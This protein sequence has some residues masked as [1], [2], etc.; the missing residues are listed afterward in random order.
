MYAREVRLGLVLYGGV[1]LAV[2]ENGVAR[3]LYHAVRGDGIYGLLKE[4]TDSDIVVDI[5]SGTSAGGVNGVM[6]SY[7]L[8]N[9]KDFTLVGDLWRDQADIDQLLRKERDDDAQSILDSD[10]YEKRLEEC[11]ERLRKTS[12]PDAPAPSRVH[13]LDLFV[14]GTDAQGAISTV[15]DDEGHSIDVK[16]HRALFQLSYRAGRIT[17]DAKNNFETA[18]PSSL[19]R[20]CR[21]TSCFPVA[22]AP[23]SVGDDDEELY[24]WRGSKGPAVYLDGGILN[25]KPF[26]STIDAINRRTANRDVERFLIY[27]EPDPE[28]FEKPAPGQIP[29][30]PAAAQAAV[31]ALV[32]V[33][34]YQ[35]I[36]ADLA[37][38]EAHNERAG[39]I[40][41]VLAPIGPAKQVAPA[42]FSPAEVCP[43][44]PD[45]ADTYLNSR[46]I[47]LRDQAVAGILNAPNGR[48]LLTGAERH[49][50]RILVESFNYWAGSASDTLRDF[51]VYFRQRRT[52]RLSKA[53]MKLHKT[54]PEQGGGAQSG[55]ATDVWDAVN[56]FF[57]LYEILEWAMKASVDE[58]E[59]GW[60]DLASSV[61][62]VD[63]IFD[64]GRRGDILGPVSAAQWGKVK[65]TLSALLDTTGIDVPAKP[66]KDGRARFHL[67]LKARLRSLPESPAAGNLLLVV[68]EAFAAV[69]RALPDDEVGNLLRGEY[70]RFLDFDRL[71]FP[72][73]F[74]TEFET[75]DSIRV[76]RFSP[77]DAQRG[78]SVGNVDEKVCGRTLGAFGGFFK[79]SWRANDIMTGR[80]DAAC[81]LVEC[82]LTRERLAKV[83]P[84][85]RFDAARVREFFENIS[86][87]GAQQLAGAL[88]EYLADPARATTE[89]WNALVDKLVLAAQAEIVQEEWPRVL[90]CA[91]EQEYQW[92][93]YRRNDA[94]PENPYDLEHLNWARA[95]KKPDRVLVALAYEAI[96]AGRIPEFRAGQI[97][98][99]PFADE[100]PEPILTELGLLG[101]IR[102]SKSL[103]AS[104]PENR[105]GLVRKNILYKWVVSRLLP[106]AYN[107]AAIRRRDPDSV[108]VINT[109]VPTACITVFL[110]GIILWIDPLQW[111]PDLK[112]RLVTTVAPAL[113]CLIWIW[114]FTLRRG[115]HRPER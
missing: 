3:E 38:I 112:I 15:Y 84:A 99:H 46:L 75:T 41:S 14:T 105:R 54:T 17:H 50:A 43:P 88:N 7:A 82:I 24:I 62:D 60:K 107:W 101:A 45:P 27:V 61:P 35:S 68:D 22:F 53:L 94:P 21:L 5:V 10:W 114:I 109:V 58:T 20:L 39:R 98:G 42:A 44:N 80:M 48:G 103:A 106:F 87:G 1:S 104:L 12:A 59:F 4:L 26:T 96:K 69:L 100:I 40:V 81:Q 92:G 79:K 90:E 18:R 25:N 64:E 73:L 34:G 57:K 95:R 65:S 23:V 67:A 97:A 19:A 115:R 86:Q 52:Q 29:T 89:Q 28:K 30:P 85:E 72:L 51:D 111:K 66:D 37:A 6:L 93:R 9:N 11:F 108:I 47:Q 13:E 78:L 56:H 76:V 77:L 63:L 55:A 102:A 49:S 70:S 113:F 83:G 8:A 110:L 36:S 71:V 33:P 2:Y 16:N 32:S 74:G 91:I 31:L